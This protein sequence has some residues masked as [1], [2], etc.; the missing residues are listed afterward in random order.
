M[1]YL[2]SIGLYFLMIKD[3]FRKPT[4]W[5]VMRTLILKDIDDL[6]ID[7][8]GIVAFISFLPH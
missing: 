5:S 8:I 2:Q 3:M 1:S 6:V 7:S 4:K